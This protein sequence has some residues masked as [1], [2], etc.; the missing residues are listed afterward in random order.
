MPNDKIINILTQFYLD[1]DWMKI[2]HGRWDTWLVFNQH[3][4]E[5]FILMMKTDDQIKVMTDYA[6]RE[7]EKIA[8]SPLTKAL[9]ETKQE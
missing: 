1:K 5:Y 9:I 4:N 7:A 6:K 2:Y 3:M 8:K